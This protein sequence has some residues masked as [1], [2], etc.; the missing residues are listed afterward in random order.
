MK[1]TATLFLFLILFTATSFSQ[2]RSLQI[3][4]RLMN[5]LTLY[6]GLAPGFGAQLVYRITKHGGIETGLYYQSRKVNYFIEAQNGGTSVTYTAQVAER[7]LQLPLLYRFDSKLLN[8]VV[9]TSLDYFLGWKEKSDNGD[10]K[11]ISYDRDALSV[12]VS[13]GISKSIYLTPTLI[14]EPEAKFNLIVTDDD[15]GLGLNLGLRKIIF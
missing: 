8:F 9:G 1:R 4:G 5:E 11:I 12:A 14:L 6:D 7:R 15:G 2:N 3:G 10:I 13:A